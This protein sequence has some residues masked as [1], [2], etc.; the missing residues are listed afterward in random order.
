MPSAPPCSTAANSPSNPVTEHISALTPLI[1][2]D[3]ADPMNEPSF[4]KFS[5][6]FTIAGDYEVGTNAIPPMDRHRIEMEPC[7]LWV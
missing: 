1:N 2:T 7:E 3:F 5:Y 6:P 4:F